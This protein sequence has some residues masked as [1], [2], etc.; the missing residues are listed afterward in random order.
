[1]RRKFSLVA[2]AADN[3]SRGRGN[4]TFVSSCG[5]IE[6]DEFY[7]IPIPGSLTVAELLPTFHICG[8]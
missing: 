6:N 2:A 4:G 1:M 8:S 5:L 7:V 3:R